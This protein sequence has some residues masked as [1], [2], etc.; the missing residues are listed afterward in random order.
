MD[1]RNLALC[2]TKVPEGQGKFYAKITEHQRHGGT[3]KL[4]YYVLWSNAWYLQSAFWGGK[5]QFIIP[6]LEDLKQ[7]TAVDRANNVYSSIIQDERYFNYYMWKHGNRSDIV[8]RILPPSYLFPFNPHGFGEHIVNRS[9]PIIVHGTAKFGKLIKGEMELSILPSGELLGKHL[10][11]LDV[12]TLKGMIGTYGCH[13]KEWQGGSQGFIWKGDASNDHSGL[14]RVAYNGDAQV[15]TCVDGTARFKDQEVLVKE[16]DDTKLGQKWRYSTESNR[17]MNLATNLC[18]DPM[19]YD[20]KT[21]P[22]VGRG[23]PNSK[24]PVQC[25]Q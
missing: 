22:Q 24:W 25:W 13:N 11:C 19:R 10:E 17:F 14:L 15:K 9:R 3:R 8:M 21:Y 16:C 18:L 5:T 4:P 1:R 12:G 20:H 23:A 6:M 2:S 7:R